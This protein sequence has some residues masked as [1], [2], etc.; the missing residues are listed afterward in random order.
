MP[1]LDNLSPEE[2][3][4]LLGP[5]S[6]IPIK[7]LI[8]E[9]GASLSSE[10]RSR[11]PPY[12]VLSASV[13]KIM[14]FCFNTAMRPPNY[15][16]NCHG[17]HHQNH[18]LPH[19]KIIDYGGCF[20]TDSPPRKWNLL[21]PTPAESLAPETNFLIQALGQQMH[22]IANRFNVSLK[23]PN[24]TE[25]IDAWSFGWLFWNVVYGGVD[26]E[27]LAGRGR[28]VREMEAVD[29]DRLVERLMSDLLAVGPSERPSMREVWK[30]IDEFLEH[31][32]NGND[33]SV[34]SG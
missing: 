26:D 3:L 15:P 29:G 5:P 8:R 33:G 25:A 19:L 17:R 14:E 7:Y 16:N 31:L 23:F 34:S 24:L 22:N 12:L 21:P 10:D 27:S 2:V 30:R 11:L 1:S 32:P 9:A 4:E 20:F 13:D 18:H 6:T 28:Y